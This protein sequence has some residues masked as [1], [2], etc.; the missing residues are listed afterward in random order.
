[1]LFLSKVAQILHKPKITQENIS[2]KQILIDVE[3]F[4][5]N[6]RVGGSNPPELTN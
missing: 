4:P 3:F 1:M 5:F 2:I 6:Q